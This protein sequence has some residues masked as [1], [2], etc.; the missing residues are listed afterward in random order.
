M[1]MRFFYSNFDTTAGFLPQH[2]PLQSIPET[3][4]F[5]IELNQIAFAIPELLANKKLGEVIAQLNHKYKNE[6]LKIDRSNARERS[7]ALLFLSMIAQ[8]YIWEDREHPKT[9]VPAVIA[10]NLMRLSISVKHNYLRYPTPSYQDYV[11]NNFY[12][13][14]PTQG[15]TLDNIEPILTFTGTKDEAWFI[16]IHI[17]VEAICAKAVDSA[18]QAATIKNITPDELLSLLENISNS[19]RLAIGVLKQMKIGCEPNYFYHVLRPHYNGWNLVHDGKQKGVLFEGIN[20]PV[21]FSYRGMS[22]AQSSDIPTLDAALHVQHQKDEMFQTLQEFKNYMPSQHRELINDLENFH[23]GMQIHNMIKNI[24]ED[25]L[26][27]FNVI[28]NAWQRA[29]NSLSSFRAQHIGFLEQ[30]IIRPS[31]LD[32]KTIVGTGGTPLTE[33]L[34]KRYESTRQAKL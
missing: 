26:F 1:Q 3:T 30:Y 33:Y 31:K 12:K 4:P 21:R 34:G 23:V 5:H 27:E 29:V 9:V 8:A 19:L 10:K 6:N 14:N 11:L 15:V 18:Y 17:V 7:V 20:L 22:G 16:K 25:Q 28:K 2:H 24:P 32:P 13:I